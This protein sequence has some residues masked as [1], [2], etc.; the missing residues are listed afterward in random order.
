MFAPSFSPYN[1]GELYLACDM[2]ELF[3]STNFGAAWNVI[4]FRQVQAGRQSSVQFTSNPLV[5]YTIDLTGIGGA[6]S[7]TPTKSGDGGLTW[8]R[9]TGDPTGGGAYALFVDPNSTNRLLSRQSARGLEDWRSPKPRGL[10]RG[11]AGRGG[12][13]KRPG[14]L[15]RPDETVVYPCDLTD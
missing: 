15:S 2:G 11:L 8:Q 7:M 6:N 10:R 13:K 14:R 5:L 4:D 3:H 12:S 9:L 1:A